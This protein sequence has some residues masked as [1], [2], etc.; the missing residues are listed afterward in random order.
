MLKILNVLKDNRG[1]TL[2][3]IIVS[4]VVMGIISTICIGYFIQSSNINNKVTITTSAQSSIDSIFDDIS[5]N[6]NNAISAHIVKLEEGPD[7]DNK[8]NDA[9]DAARVLAEVDFPDA[10]G[11]DVGYYYCLDDKII[12]NGDVFYSARSL[13][14]DTLSLEFLPHSSTLKLKLKCELSN[15]ADIRVDEKQVL[16]YNLKKNNV[17]IHSEPDGNCLIY[18]CYNK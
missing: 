13:K 5:A 10:T 16:L 7:F 2:V 6:V 4:M 17:L 12:K 8:L 11:L 1:I 9:L 14:A 15:G 3:E 18:F